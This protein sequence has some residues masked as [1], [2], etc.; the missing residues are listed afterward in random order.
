[1][2]VA[3]FFLP[4]DPKSGIL[5]SRESAAR[6][7]NVVDG[8]SVA[9]RN[10]VDG[11]FIAQ[12]GGERAHPPH[13]PV[14]SA[15]AI[16]AACHTKSPADPA[17]STRFLAR[18]TWQGAPPGRTG[19]ISHQGLPAAQV[20]SGLAVYLPAPLHADVTALYAVRQYVLAARMPQGFLPE[21]RIPAL[22]GSFAV[23]AKGLDSNT[24]RAC[25]N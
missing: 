15:P 11:P 22:S 23:A 17:R 19:P 4:Q 1:M 21:D 5:P 16:H 9:Y 18:T 6:V 25:R 20:F 24:T 3:Y 14:A 10:V 2:L 8:P 12:E 13:S 7:G